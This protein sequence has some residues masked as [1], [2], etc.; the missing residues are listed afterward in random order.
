MSAH[1]IVHIEIPG[2]DPATSGA[3]YAALFGWKTQHMAEMNYT[4]F[5]GAPGPGG[6]FVAIND[7][8]V[9]R[10]AVT[11]YVETEDIDATLQQA[12]GLGATVVAP[13][14]AIPGMGH[15]GLFA[16]PSGTVIGVFSG[17]NG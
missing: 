11:L 3:F 8:N 12:V 5:D 17:N 2:D 4:M 16:D 15:F 14:T 13:K 1:P 10:G 7:Q 6:G 9:K